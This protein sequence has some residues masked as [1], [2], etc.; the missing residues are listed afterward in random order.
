MR[1]DTALRL[2]HQQKRVEGLSRK[3][4][5]IHPKHIQKGVEAEMTEKH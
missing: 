5:E 3:H 2:S 1:A 4:H